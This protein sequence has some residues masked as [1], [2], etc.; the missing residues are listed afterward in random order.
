MSHFLAHFKGI[1]ALPCKIQKTRVFQMLLH[2]T[3]YH[4]LNVQKIN[5]QDK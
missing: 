4:L 2:L 3:Q 5:K 1:F